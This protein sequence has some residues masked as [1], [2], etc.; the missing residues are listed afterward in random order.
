MA[1]WLS[2]SLVSTMESKRRGIGQVSSRLNS[3]ASG[4][5]SHDGI[6]PR[7]SPSEQVSRSSRGPK[8]IPRL[9]RSSARAWGLPPPRR[10]ES[11]RPP[12]AP[13]APRPYSP[14]GGGINLKMI[15]VTGLPNGS[16]SKLDRDIQIWIQQKNE[17]GNHQPDRPS[18]WRDLAP[19]LREPVP[20]FLAEE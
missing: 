4:P 16:E 11:R 8:L 14:A 15:G 13:H 20:G 6:S 2:C 10:R 12:R 9:G 18:L 19:S 5:G 7:P 17:R 3:G 1:W